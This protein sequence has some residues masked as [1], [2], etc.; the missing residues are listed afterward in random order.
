M[1]TTKTLT[2]ETLHDLAE[3]LEDD[4]ATRLRLAV[5]DCRQRSGLNKARE[6]TVVLKITPHPDDND[7]ANVAPVVKL[8]LPARELDTVRVRR[9]R[10]D[11]LLFD[12]HEDSDD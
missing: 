2:L 12:L 7:D 11:G 4:F 1:A 3:D 6:L 8:K 9:T 10:K 5:E